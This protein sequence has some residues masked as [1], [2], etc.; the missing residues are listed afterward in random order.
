MVGGGDGCD[1]EEKERRMLRDVLSLERDF[2]ISTER[3]SLLRSK[4][5]R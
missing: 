4:L 2:S 1:A 3:K 5:V